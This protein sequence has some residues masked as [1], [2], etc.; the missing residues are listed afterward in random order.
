MLIAV[1]KEI[2][3]TVAEE[4][5]GAAQGAAFFANGTS[6]A[7]VT[8]LSGPLYARLGSWGFFAMIAVAIAGTALVL[9]SARS[10]PER[11]LRW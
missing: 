7:T 6:M 1:Q 10:A 8:L 3:E 5:T 2:A 4:Q 11:R 9:L